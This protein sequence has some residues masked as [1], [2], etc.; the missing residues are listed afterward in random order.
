MLR[1]VVEIFFKKFFLTKRGLNFYRI[2][3]AIE[4]NK[5]FF[6]EPRE[7][8][9]AAI[10]IQ[11]DNNQMFVSFHQIIVISIRTLCNIFHFMRTA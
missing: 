1:I 9:S 10:V 2:D 3:I 11:Y 8:N 7:I 6:H 5:Q 4:N